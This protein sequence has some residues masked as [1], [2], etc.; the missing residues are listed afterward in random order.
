MKAGTTWLY[1]VLEK[2]PDLH[3][4]REKEIHYFYHK[5][6][7]PSRLNAQARMN[8]MRDNWFISRYNPSDANI[9]HV[10]NNYTWAAHYLNSPVD[11]AWY[12]KLFYEER[13]KPYRCDFSNLNAHLPAE[14][15]EHI[16]D[17]TGKLRVI[18]VLRHPL[19]RLWSHVK[20][21]MHVT[22]GLDQIDRMS[23]RELDRFT[24]QPFLWDNA[25]YGHVLKT[26]MGSL[27]PEQ[28]KVIFFEDLH[29]NKAQTLLD[30]ESFLGISHRTVPEVVMNRRVNES[31][32]LPMPKSFTKLFKKDM[33]RVCD[34]VEV[35]GFTLPQ[36]WRA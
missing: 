28:L 6:V 26:L 31:P 35:L 23:S 11:D 19:K 18:Y 21:H 7:D 36:G 34:E 3:F 32:S 22:D 16:K 9:D 12:G 8:H 1:G 27:G 5:F 15:W 30:I 24:R 17:N 25:E 20:F 4:T 10:R 13:K 29:A 33:D 2:H 14:A